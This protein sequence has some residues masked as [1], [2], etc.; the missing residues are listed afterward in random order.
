MQT[1]VIMADTKPTRQPV[2]GSCHCGAIK[3]IAFLTLPHIHNEA[4][5]ATKKDQRIYRCNCTMCHKTGFFHISVAN[6]TEDFLL[7][8]PLT[9]LEELGD[10]LIHDKLL[11]WLHCKTCGVRCFIFMGTGEIVERDLAE[12]GVP[13]HSEKGIKTKVWRATRDG[14]HPE[15]GTYLCLNGNTI[16]ASS[17]EFD[18]RELVEQKCVMYYDFLPVEEDKQQ[19][20]RY[21]KPH[22]GGCY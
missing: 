7:L 1:K 14:G 18:M 22:A 10:Y 20:G 11:H 21:G 9:P 13:G 15:Y 6:K 5:P 2:T 19:P 17:K 8:S 12:L 3:Y 4:N 16:D